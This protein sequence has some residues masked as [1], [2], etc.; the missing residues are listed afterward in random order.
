M[1]RRPDYVRKKFAPMLDKTLRNAVAHRIGKEFPRIGGSRIRALCADMIVETV[2]AHLRPRD[3]VRHGQVLWMA[4]SVDDPPSRNKRIA[5]T[6]LVPVVLDLS[7]PEDIEAR[8]AR[9]SPHEWLTEKAVRLCHQAYKQNALLSLCD[10]AELLS[11]DPRTLS[12][13]VACYEQGRRIV[14]RRSTVH[15]VGTGLSHKRLICRK[16]YLE[17]KAPDRIAR[18]TYHSLEA[19]DRYLAVY[20]RV[21]HCRLEGMAPGDIAYTLDCSRALVDQYLAI[22]AELEEKHA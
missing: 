3:H 8:I 21:R 14:P 20:D 13:L 18:E 10:L 15:D 2:S 9:R 7:T 16:R 11:T 1:A 22:D 19:V 5:D 17:G 12:K 4:V 6:D